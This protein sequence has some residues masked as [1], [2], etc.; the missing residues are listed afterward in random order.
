MHFGIKTSITRDAN[1]PG[2]MQY[3][4]HHFKKCI[5]TSPSTPLARA[6]VLSG[7]K[8]NNENKNNKKE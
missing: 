2:R 7:G 5:F 1:A 4:V 6:R 3:T 8:K